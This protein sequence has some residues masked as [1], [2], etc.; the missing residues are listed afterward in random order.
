MSRRCVDLTRP[1]NNIRPLGCLTSLIL[2][3]TELHQDL[4]TATAA[5]AAFS[6]IMLGFM[7]NL[8]VCLA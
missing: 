5:I 6:C 2:R 4:I 8:P 1:N 7:T 3:H